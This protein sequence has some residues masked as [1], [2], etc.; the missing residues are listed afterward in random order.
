MVV[1]LKRGMIFGKSLCNVGN[2]WITLPICSYWDIRLVIFGR[3]KPL[4]L[5]IGCGINNIIR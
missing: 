2:F 4:T 1:L 5:E 3:K